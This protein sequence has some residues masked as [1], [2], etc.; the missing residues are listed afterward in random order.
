M[1]TSVL[2]EGYHREEYNCFGLTE[3]AWTLLSSRT[4]VRPQIILDLS[5]S[6]DYV[7]KHTQPEIRGIFKHKLSK[8]ASPTSLLI[9]FFR[10]NCCVSMIYHLL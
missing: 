9:K 3:I 10:G 2:R 7:C 1:K 5:I 4:Q 8:I 6:Y